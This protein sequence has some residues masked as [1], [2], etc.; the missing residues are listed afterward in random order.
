[1][2]VH[3]R[4]CH[5]AG[6][7]CHSVTYVCVCV[8]VCAWIL[9]RINELETCVGKPIKTCGVRHLSLKQFELMEAGSVVSW[10]AST[11]AGCSVVFFT[12]DESFKHCTAAMFLRP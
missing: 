5:S 6:C 3:V 8:C 1:M 7:L 10:C 2:C 12:F 9:E 4:E 11:G